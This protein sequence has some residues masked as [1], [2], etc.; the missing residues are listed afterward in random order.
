MRIKVKLYGA[1]ARAVNRANWEF[2]VSS[3]IEIFNALE[4]NTGK[5]FNHLYNNLGTEYR[6][7]L[8]GKDITDLN[9][10][11]LGNAE[12]IEVMPVL[13]G[14]GNSG[15]WLAVI[16]IVLLAVVAWWAAPAWLGAAA[17]TTTLT[18]TQSFFLTVGVALTLG[19]IAQMLAPTASTTDEEKPEN[20]PSYIYNGAINTYRQGNPVPYGAGGPM[21]VGSQ[22]I[23]AGIRSVDVVD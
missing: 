16:G 19:G 9:Q 3:P 13:K 8:D 22:I 5:A 17:A 2:E 7:L 14:A 11:V 15:A 4:A 12:E 18:A 10:L 21:I 20:K 6:F 23:S 1:L